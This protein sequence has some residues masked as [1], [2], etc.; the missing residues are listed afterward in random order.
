MGAGGW[1]QAEDKAGQTVGLMP[2]LVHSGESFKD[3]KQGN[4]V[5]T[6]SFVLFCFVFFK[7]TLGSMD[8]RCEGDKA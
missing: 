3:F 8:D 4:D 5:V 6:V 7:I 2:G 1:R